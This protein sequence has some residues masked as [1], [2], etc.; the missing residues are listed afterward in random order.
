MKFKNYLNEGVWSV[1]NTKKKV[2]EFEKVMRS[3]LT[4]KESFRKLYNIIG[5]DDLY[6]SIEDA[7]RDSDNNIDTKDVRWVVIDWIWNNW[8]GPNA[9]NTNWLVQWESDVWEEFSKIVKKYKNKF[10]KEFRK[11]A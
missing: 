11:R 1:P 9:P 5:T 10:D 2:K 4:K 8:V 6:D 7:I 3:T